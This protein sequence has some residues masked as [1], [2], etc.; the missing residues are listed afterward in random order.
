MAHDA[1]AGMADYD[2]RR[3]FALVAPIPH[4]C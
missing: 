3:V 4:N 2:E 1:K